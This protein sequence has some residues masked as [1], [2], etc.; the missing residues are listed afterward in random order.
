MN[1][2]A[3]PLIRSL[4]WGCLMLCAIAVACKDDDPCDPGQIERN[5]ACYPPAKGGNSAAGGSGGASEAGEGGG[6]GAATDTP[7]GSPCADTVGSSD[8]AGNAPVCA[9]LS[10]LGQTIMCTQTDCSTGEAHAGVCPSGF[11]CFAVP[12]YPSVCVNG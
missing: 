11:T 6:S 2:H 3:S 10:P 5:S 9:D 1:R 7:F 12:G 8:C 4:S